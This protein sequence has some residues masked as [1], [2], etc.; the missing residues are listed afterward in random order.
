MRRL[1]NLFQRAGLGGG[2]ATLRLNLRSPALFPLSLVGSMKE[3]GGGG[4]AENGVFGTVGPFI[5]EL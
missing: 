3:W 2:K 4:S 1:R 5:T